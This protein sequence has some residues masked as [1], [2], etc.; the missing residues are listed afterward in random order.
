MFKHIKKVKNNNFICDELNKNKLKSNK[1]I[2][3]NYKKITHYV[4]N[5]DL[6]IKQEDRDLKK[7]IKYYRKLNKILVRLYNKIINDN[8]YN[9]FY[10]FEQIKPEII[11]DELYLQLTILDN[12]R[13]KLFLAQQKYDDICETI[14]ENKQLNEQ[15]S[16]DLLKYQKLF[17]KQKNNKQLE[18]KCTNIQNLCKRLDS[19]LK[20]Y[21]K[22]RDTFYDNDKINQLSKKYLRHI[23]IPT[24]IENVFTDKMFILQ[25]I[26]II[27]NYIEYHDLPIKDHHKVYQNVIDQ[28]RN[29]SNILY[30]NNKPIKNILMPII[31]K[32]ILNKI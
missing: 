22:M 2:L 16:K 6:P 15:Q 7:I 9:I 3:S 10:K 31:P 20:L 11:S 19:E 27:S 28:C 8:E 29:D 23:S 21:E 4:N 17:Y 32:C 1:F 14:T 12:L 26:F 18:L 25:D 5:T 24:S 30:N 13:N